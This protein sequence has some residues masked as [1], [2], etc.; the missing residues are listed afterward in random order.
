MFAAIKS[1]VTDTSEEWEAS[2]FHSYAI[3]VFGLIYRSMSYF[4]EKGHFE[5]LLLWQ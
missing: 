3:S 1:A 2:Y 4:V 5:T